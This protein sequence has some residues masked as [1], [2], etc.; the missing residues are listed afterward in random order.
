MSDYDTPVCKKRKFDSESVCSSD[1]SDTSPS[2]SPTQHPSGI[3]YQGYLVPEGVDESELGFLTDTTLSASEKRK[4][5]RALRNRQSAQ[6]SRNKKKNHLTQLEQEIAELKA[7]N[8]RLRS[9]S[10]AVCVDIKSIDHE[11]LGDTVNPSL[12]HGGGGGGSGGISNIST[13]QSD[14]LLLD[15]IQLRAKVESLEGLVKNL[16]GLFGGINNLKTG[17]STT[18]VLDTTDRIPTSSPIPSSATHIS[19]DLN[20]DA[21]PN[22]IPQ[23]FSE[24]D[25]TCHPAAMATGPTLVSGPDSNLLTRLYALST[26][27]TI[28]KRESMEL[29]LG[30]ALQRVTSNLNSQRKY[31]GGLTTPVTL[32]SALGSA[33]VL[34]SGLEL[35]ENERG[36]ILRWRSTIPMPISITG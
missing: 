28:E 6:Q 27:Q 24:N 34:I 19:D 1:P 7:E 17:V 35:K 16:I 14:R 2:S 32:E 29:G 3:R 10:S 23:Y 30:K 31:V 15:N 9:R 11:P 22:T 18:P 33:S 12:I 25:V 5:A 8:D 36:R 4:R 21:T 20:L 26:S 13:A